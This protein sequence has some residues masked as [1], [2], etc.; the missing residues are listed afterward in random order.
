MIA[1]YLS[2]RIPVEPVTERANRRPRKLDPRPGGVLTMLHRAFLSLLLCLSV[3][4]AFLV[5]L[6]FST[7][8]LEVAALRFSHAHACGHGK[9][10]HACVCMCVQHSLG[11]YG[12]AHTERGFPACG[13]VYTLIGH[14]RRLVVEDREQHAHK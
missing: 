13:E 1:T 3:Y 7:G 4:L 9:N 14:R 10:A 12:T 6:L 8:P 11:G 2:R 5:F